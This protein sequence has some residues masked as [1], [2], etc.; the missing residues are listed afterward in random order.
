MS[1]RITRNVLAGDGS[2]E[3]IYFPKEPDL[4]RQPG[5]GSG[6]YASKEEAMSTEKEHPAPRFDLSREEYLAMDDREFRARFRERV[7]HSLEIQTY[8]SLHEGG[9]LSPRQT[10]TVDRLAAIWKE[11]GLSVELPDFRWTAKVLSFAKASQEGRKVDLSAFAPG[12]VGEDGYALLKRIVEER[13]SVRH[14]TD[15]EVPD[16]VIDE[17]LSAGSWGAH[18]CNLQSLRFVV[19]REKNEPGLFRGSDVPGGPV[20]ILALQDERVYRANPYNPSGTACSTRGRPCRTWCS[21]PMPWAWA[22]SGSPSATSC[23]RGSTPV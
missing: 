6:E 4:N 5:G 15:R 7:H 1:Q 10:E 2:C 17:I 9:S 16:S 22:A 12:A 23:W 13:R 14:W 11:R 19:A 3:R 8:A 20:H 18:S 21:R